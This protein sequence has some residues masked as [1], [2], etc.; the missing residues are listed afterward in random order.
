MLPTAAG[1]GWLA[2]QAEKCPL[3]P[4]QATR[5]PELPIDI[6]LFSICGAKVQKIFLHKERMDVR[7][8]FFLKK[9]FFIIFFVHCSR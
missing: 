1:T 8:Y 2:R 9:M 7:E 4:A 6:S 3:P 5:Y